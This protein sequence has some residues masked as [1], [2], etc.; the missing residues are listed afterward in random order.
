LARNG[1]CLPDD[2]VA[3]MDAEHAERV[4]WRNAADLYGSSLP[5]PRPS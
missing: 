4:L 1:S 2:V 3:G 5:V